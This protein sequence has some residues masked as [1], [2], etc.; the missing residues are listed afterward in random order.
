MYGKIFT[1]MYDGSLGTEG[2][3]QALVTFQQ[4]IILADKDGM[5]DITDE[6]IARRTSIPL[7]VIRPGIEA[8]LKPDPRSRSKELDGRRI[9][10]I[11]PDRDWGWRIVNY[12]TYRRI[13][14][15]DE[16]REYLRQAQ[17]DHRANVKLLKAKVLTGVNGHE[18]SSTHV[19]MSTGST[20]CQPIAVSSKQYAVKT[21]VP[22]EHCGPPGPP[23]CPHQLI[24]QTFHGEL[25][26]CPRVETWGK[27]RQRQLR[28]RW[29]DAW[30]FEAKKGRPWKD[31]S[32]GIAWFGR[33][34]AYCKQ[35]KFLMGKV[36]GRDGNPPFELKLDWLIGPKNFARIIEG[37]FHREGGK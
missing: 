10:P 4:L 28:Q 7:E 14:S 25:P 22:T 24:L 31:A 3:W 32:D 30:E 9:I 27:D 6:A 37:D 23:D 5:V 16:R 21:C 19:N 8:L 26:T 18:T 13:R 1:Q 2:P 20:Q 36:P 11:D 35:S 34:F 29:R 17:E 15:A 12:A 33:M